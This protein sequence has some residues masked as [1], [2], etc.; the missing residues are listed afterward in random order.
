[1]SALF[2][3]N[4]FSWNLVTDLRVIFAE[5]FMVNAYVGG[6]LIAVLAGLIG[7]FVVL[8]RL[9][10]ANHALGHTGFSGA[11]AAVLIGVQPIYGLLAFT[12]VTGGG[13]AVMGTRASNRDVE[14]GTMLAFALGL[15]LLFLSL[16]QGYAQ[17][18]YSILFGEV[19]GISVA[20]LW[21]TVYAAVGILAAMAFLYR[22]L[23]FSSLDEDVAEAKGLP[24]KLLG[25]VFM[26]F[27]A[28]AISF[29]VTVIG[30]LLIFAL[31]VTPAAI[32]VRL[33]RRSWSAIAV[34]IT[35]AVTAVWA[36]LFLSWYLNPPV[37]FFICGIIFFEYLL[38]R[39]SAAIRSS[40]LLRGVSVPELDAVSRLRVA[41]VVGLLSQGLVV[42]ALVEL[43]PVVTLDPSWIWA[44]STYAAPHRI[45]TLLM[46]GGIALA[47]LSALLY[48][49]GFRGVTSS[50]R[51]FV[52]PTYLSLLGLLGIVLAS[53]GLYLVVEGSVLG[54]AG[55]ALAAVYTLFGAP[56]LLV[57]ALLAF[58]GLLGQVVG[59]WRASRLYGEL[60]FRV[61][62]VLL[63]LPVIGQGI[64]CL[65]Y[66]GVTRKLSGPGRPRPVGTEG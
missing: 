49:L 39:G 30:V 44:A 19:L 13:M 7:Y 36:G 12:M 63:F 57:G 38:V 37:S 2:S 64:S 34:S 55:Y 46:A 16:Y 54:N 50:S 35:I 45:G 62:A 14:I 21:L 3:G 65:G 58:L 66:H 28:V 56:M 17:Q 23:L 43:A 8:R 48:F 24:M 26:L 20:Q 1:M 22:P 40:S 53:S 5:G 27:L 18:A 6:T 59:T 51:S 61:G 11:A 47:G 41:G 31:M 52:L 25:L 10:F 15:G 60:L 29:A 33:T 4:A 42:L 32:A 9:A